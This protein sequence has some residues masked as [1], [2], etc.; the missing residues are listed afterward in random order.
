MHDLI[1]IYAGEAGEI[2]LLSQSPVETAPATA[3]R[4]VVHGDQR[5]SGMW[6]DSRTEL[7]RQRQHFDNPRSVTTPHS[8]DRVDQGCVSFP[9]QPHCTATSSESDLPPVAAPHRPAPAD[10]NGLRL[11]LRVGRSNFRPT[12]APLRHPARGP[13]PLEPLAVGAGRP[14]VRHGSPPGISGNFAD[15]YGIGPRLPS[16]SE[17]SLAHLPPF[18][19]GASMGEVWVETSGT[20]GR[21]WSCQSPACWNGSPHP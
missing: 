7:I 10:H 21:I 12:G 19:P 5:A 20:G 18:A 11:P 16:G 15:R 13:R 3:Q 6:R 8:I 17:R 2:P 1:R 4:P 14:G 9:G